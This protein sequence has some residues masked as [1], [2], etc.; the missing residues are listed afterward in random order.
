MARAD[1]NAAVSVERFFQFSVLGL[2]AS[3]YLAVAGSGYLDKPTI[4]LT[5]A[6]LVLR[7]LLISGVLQM[8]FSD[9]LVTGL[10]LGYMGFF[11]LDYL[12]LS[13][14]FLAATVHLVFFLAVMKVLTSKTS[15]DYLYTAVIAFLELLAA[16]ILSINLNF[17]VFLALFLLF[18]IAALTSSEIR[19]S[20]AKSPATA[21][22]GVRRFHPRLAALSL[23]ATLGI[24]LLTA[25]LFFFLPRTADA[26]FAHLISHRIF[27]P[28]LSDHVTLGEIGE[29]K[30]SSRPVMHI[31]VYNPG[32]PEP[33][34][35]RGGALTGFDGRHWFNADQTE[36]AIPADHGHV[37]LSGSAFRPNGR[38]ISY[39]V[40][41]DEIENDA[42]FFAGTPEQV[43]LRYPGIFRTATGSFRL[44]HAPPPSFRYEA[45][46]LL[47][48][49]PEA[50]EPVSP[51]PVLDARER[52]TD[53][54]LPPLD[55]RIPQ[56]ARTM[57]S[58]ATS[59]LERAR[60]IERHLRSDFAYT[61]Q[62]P[63][64]EPRDPLAYFLFTRKKGHC[65][66]FASAMAVMLRTL[67]IP[68]RLATGFQSGIY[69]PLTELW[70]IRASDAHSWV[71]AWIPGRGWTTFDPTPPEPPHSP[72][73]LT[74]AGLYLDAAQTFWQEWVVSYDPG[75]QG[76]LADRLEQDAGRMGIRWFDSLSGAPSRWDASVMVWLRHDGLIAAGFL[77]LGGL[78]WFFVPPAFR[79]LGMRRRVRRVRLG[80]ASVADA[81][82]LYQR[83]LQILRRRGYQKPLWFTPRE[84]ASSLPVPMAVTVS[85]FTAAYNAMRYGGRTDLAARLSVLLDELQHQE[86]VS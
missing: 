76:T 32:P 19:R 60:D 13:R 42:L 25:G 21:R 2:V 41:M 74:R 49:P 84:F 80:Q 56:L 26:A 39:I 66:Y 28:G 16:A 62:L 58:G 6:G 9:R 65:E 33:F 75:H 27:L 44:G 67:N 43:E 54:Q 78:L 36:D 53:L 12:A 79:L 1:A 35:W 82:V 73:L 5:A 14:S 17:F 10:T 37:N 8:D 83:M 40:E 63:S 50:A 48:E 45:Y 22:R 38:R 77:A 59:D 72:S 3:G 52:E 7:A 4:A 23:L 11:G 70:L 31:S 55:P 64:A 57:S 47:E 61:L 85:E 51:P 34:K 71:E 86:H 69:N 24:L 68:S 18:A 81:T 29:I 46:S 20:M 30:T 15:R